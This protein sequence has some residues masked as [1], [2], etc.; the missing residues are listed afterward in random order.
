[1]K[2]AVI[3]IL[4]L[5]GG[6]VE[7][8]HNNTLKLTNF[9]QKHKYFFDISKPPSKDYINTLSLLI[10]KY[11][12]EYDI[13]PIFTKEAKALQIKLLEENEEKRNL[14]IFND[15]YLIQDE[16]DYQDIL[17]LINQSLS[18]ANYTNFI[19]DLT[20]GF[21]HLPILATINLIMVNIKNAQKI[22][23]I[24]FAKELKKPEKKVQ[25]EY[26]I[27][28]L[29]E[30]LDLANLSYIIVNFKN[31]YTTS[32]HIKIENKEFDD[33]L[34]SMNN[35]SS[36]LMALSLENLFDKTQPELINTINILLKKEKTI[37]RSNLED[38]KKHL[39]TIFQKKSHRFITYYYLA[40]DLKLKGYLVIALSLLFEAI[41]FY[42][43]SSFEKFD[44]RTKK[45]IHDIENKIKNKK[46]LK[47]K[48]EKIATYYDILTSCRSYIT[49]PQKEVIRHSK[50]IKK[51]NNDKLLINCTIYE[52][53]YEIKNLE[54]FKLFV[55]ETLDTR[56]NLLHANSGEKVDMIE[57][58]LSEIL[59]N[60]NKFCIVDDVLS[61]VKIKEQKNIEENAKIQWGKIENLND[62]QELES[63]ITKSKS[64]DYNKKAQEIID[65]L[66]KQNQQLENEK[67]KSNK[68]KN[69]ILD[70]RKNISKIIQ[71]NSG[72]K[73]RKNNGKNT[74]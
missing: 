68:A 67:Q 44:Y 31:N 5:A 61:Y 11:S 72:L 35:F 43:K 38:L 64:T 22:E 29:K 32:K 27:I 4:G 49:H 60:F 55:E 54:A 73:K 65:S 57:K 25:G 33:L 46:P 34:T 37:L 3:S 50:T 71:K 18:D 16:N 56:N 17:R 41:G 28:D 9:E 58:K 15:K 14:A 51:A 39:E 45:T 20:H 1:M 66:K 59:I 74:D 12:T 23:K 70:K 47:E 21:R 40:E 48:S 10:D 6:K 53:L 2:K 24:W 19:V 30:Y 26:H 7:K 69:K 8:Q 62:I 13:I 52:K 42:I 36:D 63:F